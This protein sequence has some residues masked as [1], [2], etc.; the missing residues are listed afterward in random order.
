MANTLFKGSMLTLLFMILSMVIIGGLT[1]LTGSGLSIVEWKPIAGILP[2][3]F[4]EEW[5]HEFGKYQQSP[6]FQKINAH[7]TLLEFRAIF[8]REYI[9]RLG[10]RLLGLVLLIPTLLMIFKKYRQDL[11]LYLAFLW[12]LGAAQGES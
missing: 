11:W 5:L 6:E 10:G 7:M 4:L 12:L 8:W 2:P 3:L 1:R 9:H